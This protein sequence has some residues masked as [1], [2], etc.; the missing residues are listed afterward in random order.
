MWYLDKI[1][2]TFNVINP[3]PKDNKIYYELANS[4]KIIFKENARVLDN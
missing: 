2:D 3:K 1:G 4:N